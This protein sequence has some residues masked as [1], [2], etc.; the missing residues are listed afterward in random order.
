MQAEPSL[1]AELGYW[2]IYATP[3]GKPRREITL[4][5]GAPIIPTT[6]SFQDPFSGATA[7][8]QANQITPW[9]NL[10][11]GD[12]DWVSP[13][14]NI[15][16][17]WQNTGPYT[18]DW[19]W[20]GYIVNF[21]FDS[22][23]EVNFSIT[24][25]GAL[26]GLDDYLATPSFPANPIPYELLI[27]D[28]FD[29]SKHPA[30]LG[31][32]KITFPEDWTTTVP[33][34]KDP[35]YLNFLKPYGVST[36]QK[37]TGLTSRST[38]S[39]E[40]LLTGF[41]QTLLGVMYADNGA[42]WTIRNRGNRRPELFL[43]T[44]PESDDPSIIEIDMA[45]PGVKFTG[46]KDFTQRAN[47]IY[48]S[49]QDEAG[50]T[51]NGMQVSP[52]GTSTY[53][54][55][56]AFSPLVY[57]RKG[58]ASYDKSV[59]PKEVYLQF[60]QGLSEEAAFAVAQSQLY[61]FGEPGYTGTVTLTSD[62]RQADGTPVPRMLIREGR[63]IRIKNLGGLKEGVLA[64]VSQVSV[65]FTSLT[66]TL[67]YDTKYR[68]QLTVSEVQAR[69]RDALNPT[70]ALQVGK[71]SA[72]VQ[73]LLMPWS[74]AN[75]SGCIPQGSKP[76]FLEKLPADAAFPY[77]E[78][79][80][81]YPPSNPAYAPYY[82]KIPGV[83]RTDSKKNWS[84]T[85]RDGQARLAIPI[86]MAQAGTV[87]LIQIAAYDKNGHVLPVKFHLSFYTVNTTG[88][89][90]MPIYSKN[91]NYTPAKTPPRLSVRSGHPA[92]WN[93]R[94]WTDS[95]S[96]D[97]DV[98]GDNTMPFF[99]GA[100]ESIDPNGTTYP[101][102]WYQPTQSA[103]LVVGW[104]NYY[105]PAGFW[106][107]RFSKGAQATGMLSDE[108]TWTWDLSNTLDPHNAAHPTQ[109][110]Y[111]VA[112]AGMLYAMLYCEEQGDQPVYFLGRAFRAEPGTN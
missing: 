35:A 87:K 23:D 48:G 77:E 111:G 108:S 24:L 33:S 86:R 13:D 9:D 67:T 70:H 1:V 65:D 34:A 92:D 102:D 109:G 12:L 82:I 73:D 54:Q 14:T 95:D 59:K 55:P 41:C 11:T 3:P 56:Y 50:I 90:D 18:F 97:Y 57:P 66:T 25:K 104:G 42:Q 63:T 79:T 72:T 36:G 16:I 46:S 83:S 93:P 44:V 91:T 98:N 53:Y 69:T 112:S 76:F 32:L 105:E 40:Y 80:T 100:W 19:S 106:P 15:D 58:N 26:Y 94:G 5:R 10:G 21:D 101:D 110:Q 88:P 8:I 49:G 2:R 51:Y 20:E 99:Q 22:G 75:G 7:S 17:V 52:D 89:S 84:A 85:P 39:W 4:F 30:S 60:Q 107:G 62:V 45:A 27:K 47:V 64:H 71:D 78:Y 6:V 96:L 37:W 74:Y 31:P 29:Q 81:Q 103:G 43:R 61:R 28:A 38:G 68:D